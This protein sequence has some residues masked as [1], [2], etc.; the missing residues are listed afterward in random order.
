MHLGST[1]HTH[2]DNNKKKEIMSNRVNQFFCYSLINCETKFMESSC[3]KRRE[4]KTI[5][6]L[7]DYQTKIF[8][9]GV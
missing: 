7:T 4:H 6:Y 1:L 2:M 9:K 3:G 8:T 5:I